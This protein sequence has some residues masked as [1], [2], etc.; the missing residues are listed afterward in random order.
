VTFEMP[1]F[2]SRTNPSVVLG[3]GEVFVLDRQLGLAQLTETVTVT[4]EVPKPPPVAPGPSSSR[5][6]TNGTAAVTRSF[7]KYRSNLLITRRTIR[8][9]KRC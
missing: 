7:C 1:G 5:G 9:P 3:P 8:A 2:E 6:R 4:G